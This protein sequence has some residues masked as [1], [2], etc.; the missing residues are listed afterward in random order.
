M[1]GRHHELRETWMPAGGMAPESE[2][3]SVDFLRDLSF[4]KYSETD[5]R[6]DYN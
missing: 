4:I 5:L 1:Q 6:D 3:G 2:D